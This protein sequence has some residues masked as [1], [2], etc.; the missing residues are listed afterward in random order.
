M[1]KQ[2]R[3]LPKA[4]RHKLIRVQKVSPLENFRAHFVFTDGSERDIDLD[5]YLDGGVFEPIRQ[6][7]ELFRNMFV[8]GG[9]ITWPGEVDIDPDTLYYGDEDPPWV[10]AVREH[11]LKTQGSKRALSIR[12]ARKS[13]NG[14]RANGKSKPKGKKTIKRRAVKPGAMRKRVSAKSK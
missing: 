2:L 9:T 5:Q 4:R 12:T 8:E 1:N 10:K 14:K 6:D 13:A 7:P 3:Q 11:E